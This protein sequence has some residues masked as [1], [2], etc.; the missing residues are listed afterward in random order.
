MKVVNPTGYY[1]RDDVNHVQINSHYACTLILYN[2]L[3]QSVL[4]HQYSP[5]VTQ[6]VLID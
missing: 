2:I 6:G 5:A 1:H 3:A 4:A